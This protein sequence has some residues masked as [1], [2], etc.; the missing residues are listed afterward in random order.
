MTKKFIYQVV[1]AGAMACGLAS[2]TKDLDRTPITE[3]TSASVY[4]D[5]SNYKGILAKLYGGFSVTG[6]QGPSGNPDI[7]GI[8]EGT[9]SYIRGYFQ[10]QELPTDEAVIGWN[11]GTLQDFH[12]MD[13]TPDDNFISAMFARLFYQI[14][15][16]NEFIR[17]TSDDK[18]GSNGIAE[19][20][21]ETARTFRAE[22]RFLRALSY[23]HAMDLFGSVPF[24]T[25]SNEVAFYYPDQISRADLF[26]YI[27]RELKDIESSMPEARSNEYGRADRA[28]VWALL[29]KMYLN[30]EV[31]TGT[32]RYTDAVTYSS[33]VINSGY[34]LVTSY[35]N[36]FK[37]DNNVTSQNEFLLTANFDGLRTQ[38]YG[39]TTYLV[40]AAIGGNMDAAAFGVNGGWGGLRTTSAFVN[41]FTDLT[42]ATDKR[43]MFHTEG[44]NR[45][46]VDL[47]TFTDGY[48]IT[49]WSNK[50]STGKD[51][52]NG[53]FV[54]VDFPLMRVAEMYLTYAEAVLRGGTGG[55]AATALEYINDLRGRAYGNASGNITAGQLDLRFILDERGRELYWEGHRRTDLIRYGLFTGSGYVWPFKGGVAAGVAVG[56]FRTIY[57]IPTTARVANPNLV[58]NKGY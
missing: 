7:S 26:A 53:T 42:G 12:Q 58:Q 49:K 10:M 3:A 29:A 47:G 36:M 27:E 28:C 17:Q 37:A 33:Q 43:A 39:G 24:V 23:Y 52:S 32:G 18:L 44:Q 51:G 22:A 8:D 35:A 6:Q 20:D 56:D 38:T 16:C 46:I 25:D 19:K 55:S 4:R 9:S 45:E 31:Y 5:F 2:C 11:D 34:G 40:H 14:A 15:Q 54:D 57:P 30:A 13:W 48:A 1:L 41:L 50:T 21:Q